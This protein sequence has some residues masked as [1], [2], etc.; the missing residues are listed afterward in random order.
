VEQVNHLHLSLGDLVFVFL[1]FLS[2]LEGLNQGR[3]SLVRVPM[4]QG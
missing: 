3:L 2:C 1:F 4:R